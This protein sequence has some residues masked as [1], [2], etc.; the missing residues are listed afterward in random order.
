MYEILSSLVQRTG[1]RLHEN[2]QWEYYIVNKTEIKC[3]FGK[4]IKVNLI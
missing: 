1:W 3:R 4:Q 2:R